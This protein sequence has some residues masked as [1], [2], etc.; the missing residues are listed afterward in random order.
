VFNDSPPAPH[1]E[2]IYLEVVKVGE[3]GIRRV[4]RRMEDITLNKCRWILYILEK[5]PPGITKFRIDSLFML[6]S[7][8]PSLVTLV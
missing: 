3:A 2:E 1:G 5:H 7:G 4:F 8:M 6:A